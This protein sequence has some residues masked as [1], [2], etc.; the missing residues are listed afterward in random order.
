M[1]DVNTVIKRCF[2]YS[3]LFIRS[4]GNAVNRER[5]IIHYSFLPFHN[6]NNRKLLR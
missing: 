5:D 4:N 1:R 6:P 3:L 2:K